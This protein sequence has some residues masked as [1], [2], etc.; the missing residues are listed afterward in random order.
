MIKRE[1]KIEALRIAAIVIQELDGSCVT[2]NFPAEDSGKI[3]T[4]L[5]KIANA[6]DIKAD[7]LIR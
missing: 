7:K 4:E 6:L 2:S 1:A 5:R 3:K